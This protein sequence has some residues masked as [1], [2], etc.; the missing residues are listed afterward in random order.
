[1]TSSTA[2]LRIS[3]ALPAPH[4]VSICTFCPSVQPNCAS[5]CPKRDDAALTFRVRRS[6]THEHANSPNAVSLLRMRRDRP[7][8]C[9]SAEQ[10]YEL[11]PFQLIELHTLLLARGR[12]RITDWHDQVRGSLRCGI[13]MRSLSAW[14]SKP[15]WYLTAL[16]SAL[17][18]CGHTGTLAYVKEV[19]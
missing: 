9:R 10:R 18:S 11:T 12:D 8:G 2:C 14:G 6:L 7:R 15:E 5:P 13:S 3:S 16:T 17:T 1:M 4:R 19:P